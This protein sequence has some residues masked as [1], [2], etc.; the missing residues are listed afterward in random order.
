MAVKLISCPACG[1]KNVSHRT[2]CLRCGA[3]VRTSKTLPV[4]RTMRTQGQPPAGQKECPICGMF[5]YLQAPRCY[6]GYEFGPE[7]IAKETEAVPQSNEKHGGGSETSDSDR[8][9][10]AAKS[11]LS[12]GPTLFKLL[13]EHLG[14]REI[15]PEWFL[16]FNAE[17]ACYVL[18]VLDRTLAMP[19]FASSR[20]RTMTYLVQYLRDAFSF[21]LK[22]MGYDQFGEEE[23]AEGIDGESFMGRTEKQIKQLEDAG[24]T[25][26]KTREL[27][28]FAGL[29]LNGFTAM[30]NDRQQEYGA[31]KKESWYGDV[32]IRFGKHAAQALEAEEG[33][34]IVNSSLLASTLLT[35]L[36]PSLT[37]LADIDL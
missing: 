16:L 26:P 27:S 12:A 31:L 25:V 37:S 22:E 6:C 2:V 29:V 9:V 21:L 34:A 13:K 3:A 5:N 11:I 20:D 1:T 36:L 19:A 32:A 30:Y 4:N 17:V 15:K 24:F 10:V 7:G 35:E 23:L 18:H 33:A 28:G 14:D 8:Y